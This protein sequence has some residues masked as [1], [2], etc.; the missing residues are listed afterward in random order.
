MAP[1]KHGKSTGASEDPSV[2]LFREYLRIDTVHP[3]PDYGED[4]W[5]AGRGT[6]RG[7]GNAAWQLRSLDPGAQVLHGGCFDRGIKEQTALCLISAGTFGWGRDVSV[8]PEMLFASSSP[9]PQGLPF[10][11]CPGSGTDPCGNL[12]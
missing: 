9:V 6:V 11:C 3:K 12:V 10:P 5:G 7:S 4:G 1:G 2:T 8:H